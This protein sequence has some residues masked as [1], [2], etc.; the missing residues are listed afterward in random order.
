[1]KVEWRTIVGASFFLFVIF[2]IYLLWN[3]IP[4]E[5]AGV[6]M[7]LFGF[8]AYGMLGAYLILQYVR[9]HRLP[10]PED[11]FDAD[12][13]DGAGAVAYFPSASIWP[14]GVG[15]AAVFIGMAFIYGNWYWVVGLPLLFGAIIGWL[16][17]S[18][19]SLDVEED[20]PE[21]LQQRTVDTPAPTPGSTA[22]E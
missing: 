6:V 2:V 18:E 3:N 4:T 19:H 22:H 12:Q 17:E 14:A 11:R 5:A 7:L 21:E 16:V 1:M 20:V 8:F 15:I 9:R 13:S 10:R